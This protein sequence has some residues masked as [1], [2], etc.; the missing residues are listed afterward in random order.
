MIAVKIA[1]ENVDMFAGLVLIAPS[2]VVRP[3]WLTTSATAVSVASLKLE[4]GRTPLWFAAA[5]GYTDAVRVL[6]SAT[7]GRC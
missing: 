4:T 6:V 5:N 7:W 2:F 3:R 1:E